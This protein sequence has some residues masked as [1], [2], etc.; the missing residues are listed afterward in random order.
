MDDPPTISGTPATTASHGINYSFVPTA[1]DVD[2]PGPLSFSISNKPAWASF[3]TSTGELSGIPGS[4]NVGN[5]TTGVV[6]TVNAGGKSDSLA[7][8]DLTV[9][10]S[11]PTFTGTPAITGTAKV[12][13]TLGLTDTGTTDNDGDSVSLSYQWAA[14]SSDIPG[15]VNASYMV[16]EEEKGKTLTCTLTAD[17]GQ[18]G[19][20]DF[21]TAGVKVQSFNW[22]IF[23]RA[24]IPG[25][26]YVN[27][28]PQQLSDAPE[29]DNQ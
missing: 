4:V 20:T 21:T 14:D 15:A 22:M 25:K 11:A 16:T 7:A 28:E 12:E 18:G 23:Y 10:N 2:G 9:T 24:F 19:S 6:I 27:V 5:T 29:E 8:F 26:N 17:D 13:Q 1:G 3:D